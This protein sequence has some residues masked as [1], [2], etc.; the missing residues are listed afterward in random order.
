MA[1]LLSGSNQHFLGH[2]S[3]LLGST[4][5]AVISK[6][7]ECY[8]NMLL[9]SAHIEAPHHNLG[10]DFSTPPQLMKIG[11][12]YRKLVLC[13]RPI[14]SQNLAPGTCS[15]IQFV[16]RSVFSLRRGTWSSIFWQVCLLTKDSKGM[17][18][19]NMGPSCIW[20]DTL[21]TGAAHGWCTT[22]E[23]DC[24]ALAHSASLHPSP[25]GRALLPWHH[26]RITN[27][28]EQ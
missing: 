13:A 28:G 1:S 25:L 7:Y 15:S 18:C 19:L 10:S 11:V 17:R 6:Y 5:P 16:V 14:M 21:S 2:S 4:A 24:I 8:S 9:I 27:I 12:S 20:H 22:K 23:E 26:S 3:G